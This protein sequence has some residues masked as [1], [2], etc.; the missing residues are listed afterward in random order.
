MSPSP[1]SKRIKELRDIIDEDVLEEERKYSPQTRQLRKIK[2]ELKELKDKDRL[3]AERKMKNYQK[4]KHKHKSPKDLFKRL[5]KI[6]TKYT[7]KNEWITHLNTYRKTHPN[8]N[9]QTAM[10]NAKKTYKKTE[11]IDDNIKRRFHEL[12]KPGRVGPGG[13]SRKKKTKKKKK[14]KKKT[15]KKQRRNKT[16]KK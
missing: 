5:N 1:E 2:R 4:V 14:K 15:K 10:K 6:D 8:I 16:K 3:S 13:G 12:Q 11:N 7:G 9:L